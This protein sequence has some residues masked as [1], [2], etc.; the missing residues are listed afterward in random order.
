MQKWYYYLIFSIILFFIPYSIFIIG[1]WL[2]VGVQFSVLKIQFS[3]QGNSTIDI[4]QELRY[5]TSGVITGKSVLTI[6]MWAIGSF[7]IIISIIV[8]VIL[9]SRQTI[10]K[11][12]YGGMLLILA[13]TFFLASIISQYGIL[14][15]G[16][17]GVAIPVGL[18]VLFVI[19][20]WMYMEGRKEEIGD[21]EEMAQDI[22]DESE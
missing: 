15:N 16:P 20:G 3:D 5:L 18:P 17:A 12:K 1:D 11:I 21:E 9:N 10:P 22:D 8:L 4:L 19:G 7:C 14:F 13:A 2:G 6:L